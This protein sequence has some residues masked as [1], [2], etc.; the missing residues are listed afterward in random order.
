MFWNPNY[1]FFVYW[2][3]KIS[4][5][6]S[7]K[8]VTA[9]VTNVSNEAVTRQHI[10]TPL[11]TPNLVN[12]KPAVTHFL[13]TL[14]AKPKQQRPIRRN[15]WLWFDLVGEA[16]LWFCAGPTVTLARWRR[17]PQIVYHV[18][19]LPPRCVHTLTDC[20]GKTIK[21]LSVRLTVVKFYTGVKH[22]HVVRSHHVLMGCVQTAANTVCEPWRSPAYL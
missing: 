15:Y 3:N 8:L 1:F 19:R 5:E 11:F 22:I 20:R 18:H 9:K 6:K 10:Q 14:R 17:L 4:S 2:N 7:H 12:L 21:L 16:S 13:D